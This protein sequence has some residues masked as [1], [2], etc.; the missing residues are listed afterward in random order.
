MKKLEE[1][2]QIAQETLNQ[3]S[4]VEPSFDTSTRS[5]IL[6]L[7]TT[8]VI[9][10]AFGAAACM[11]KPIFNG[12]HVS[13]HYFSCRE[14]NFYPL[15]PAKRGDFA[16]GLDYYQVPQAIAYIG[17]NHMPVFR[18]CGT[19]LRNL[20]TQVEEIDGKLIDW[21]ERSRDIL[22]T[23]YGTLINKYEIIETQ[24]DNLINDSFF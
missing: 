9:F 12:G 4:G 3:V 16:Y 7:S 17:E 18:S 1:L 21:N 8:M 10:G 13:S 20:A 11:V 5:I 23:K 6:A 22:D 19:E 15:D 2:S 14:K 24:I